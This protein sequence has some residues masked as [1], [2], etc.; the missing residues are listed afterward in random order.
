[1]QKALP[2]QSSTLAYTLL[3]LTML[4]WAGN[5]VVGKWAAGNIPPMTLAFL[6]WSGAALIMLPIAWSSLKAERE[7]IRANF[8]RMVMLG[9]LGSGAYN[10]LQYLAL[11]ETTVTNA[12]ILNSWAPV[13]IAV[14][15]A[16]LF[17]DKLK[18]WQIAGLGISLVGVTTI[19]LKGSLATL[20]GFSFNIGDVL[21]LIATAIWAGYTTLL[22][23]RPALSTLSF[24]A[25]TYTVAGLANLPLAAYEYANGQ[26]M[27]ATPQVYL[28]VVFTAIFPS[29]IAYFFYARGVEII[30]ATR[31]GAFI[32]LIPL[33][34]SIMAIVFLGEQPHLYHAAGFGLILTGVW[35]ASRR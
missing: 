10:T 12:A 23:T 14:A 17:A 19:V 2:K 21:M 15:G 34:A 35:L 31:T 30:G 22:R 7:A 26:H 33:F 16:I 20:A 25:F 27:L 11:T 8:G 29:C 9:I 3:T 5:H 18:P 13:L 1:M 28:A 24:A 32:H 6:R 4:M